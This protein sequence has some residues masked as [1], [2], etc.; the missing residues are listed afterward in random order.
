MRAVVATAD[1]TAELRDLP[2]PRPR[3]GELLVRVTAVGLCGSDVEKLRPGGAV[4]GTVLGHEI[5][6]E[7]EEG[8]LP[9]GTRVAVAHRVPCGACATCLLGHETCCPQFLASGLRPGGFCERTVA[10]PPIAAAA[11]LALPDAVGDVAGTFVE[12]LA[13]VLRGCDAL[14]AGRGAVIG[15]GVIGRLFL[16]ALSGRELHVA[17]PDGAR[18]VAA[19]DEA[20]GIAAPGDGLDFAVVTAP[21]GLNDALAVLR[22]GGSCLVF[23][24]PPE[25]VPVLLD[26][27]Y[28]RE[29]HLLGSRSAT[30]PYL[31]RALRMIADGS[32]AVADLVD[33]ELPLEEFA[34]GVARYRSGAARKV[35]FRP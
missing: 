13:C 10:P 33:A 14:P 4:D 17:D 32:V 11:V 1:G 2:A 19:L 6:G 20:A 30:P 28:R 23:A 26:L 21:A 35:V 12:P 15:C 3:A 8:P 9:V 18:L 31:A 24:A 7:V 25:P 27:V 5:A 22:P 16:R 29:L 34:D